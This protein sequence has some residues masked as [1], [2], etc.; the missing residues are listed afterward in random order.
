MARMQPWMI[1]G[2]NGY[3]GQLIAREAVRRGHRPILAGRNGEAVRK[4]ADELKLEAR[5]FDLGKAQLGGVA[6]VVHCAGPFSQTSGPM[7][8][9]CLAHKVHYLD[10]TGELEVFESVF[11]ADA[12]ARERGITLLPGVGF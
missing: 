11:A 3:T 1:Y 5:V 9:A 12:A 10:I 6:L 8:E 2:A 7:V 4:L